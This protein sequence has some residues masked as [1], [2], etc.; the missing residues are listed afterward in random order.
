MEGIRVVG[1]HA[2]LEDG[3]VI[4]ETIDDRCTFC[5]DDYG[6]ILDSL[7][8]AVQNLQ[9]DVEKLPRSTEGNIQHDA[10]VPH[11]PKRVGGD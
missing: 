3:T 2:I 1:F 10:A 4:N 9:G 5:R 8:S 11:L 7:T 6:V